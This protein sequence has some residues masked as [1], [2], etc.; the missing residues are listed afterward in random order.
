MA[1]TVRPNDISMTQPFQS[2]M[3]ESHAAA[4]AAQTLVLLAQKKGGWKKFRANEADDI[5][6]SAFIF[7][8]LTRGRPP[9]IRQ[10]DDDTYSFTKEFI[11]LCVRA[12]AP[13]RKALKEKKDNNSLFIPK[14]G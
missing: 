6:G 1:H 3:F 10:N 4:S 12:M 11:D 2:S 13:F 8:G 14:D 5:L 7:Y 9:L